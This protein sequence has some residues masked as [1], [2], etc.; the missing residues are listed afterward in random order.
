[1]V[2]I[3]ESW[4]NKLLDLGKR[5]KLIN[6]KPAKRTTL[7]LTAPD[8]DSLF[9]LLVNK[10]K[11]ISFPN[12]ESSL[13]DED[14]K[15]ES[16]YAQT[17]G[18]VEINLSGKEM[19]STLKNL[20]SKSKISN[21]E[22]GINTLFLTFGMIEWYESESSSIPFLS[23]LVLVPVILTI[24]DINSPY[25]LTLHDDEIVVNPTLSYKLEHDFNIKLPEF[26]LHEEPIQR[27][28]DKVKMLLKG[29]RRWS[30]KSEAF[31]S[32]LSF[33]KINMYKDIVKNE[34]K[35]VSNPLTLALINK[36][37]FIS[38]CRE[39]LKDFEM[40]NISPIDL[41]QVVDA[42]SSQQEAIQYSKRGISFVL[43]G[44]P[45]TG[46]SQTITNII[47][48][49]LADGKKVLFVSEKQAALQVVFNRLEQVNLA[50]FCLPLHSFK[51]NRK[52]ILQSLD[53]SL[54]LDRIKIRD[55]AIN[56]LRTLENER[57][58]LNEYYRELHQVIKPLNKSF[59]EI[60][61]IIASFSNIPDKIFSIHEIKNQT[62]EGVFEII[63]TI[64]KYAQII[65]LNLETFVSSPW[66]NSNVANVT[67][68]LRHDIDSKL[69][70]VI[71]LVEQQV[72]YIE[73]CSELL[74]FNEPITINSTDNLLEILSL[75]SCAVDYPKSWIVDFEVGIL[76]QKAKIHKNICIELQTKKTKLLAKYDENIFSIEANEL[77]PIV[78]ECLNKLGKEL[79]P[80]FYP[81]IHDTK[82]NTFEKYLY[83]IKY[84]ATW[85]NSLCNALTLISES[86]GLSRNYKYSD[87]NKIGLLYSSIKELKV[88]VKSWFELDAFSDI[89]QFSQ[90][91]ILKQDELKKYTSDLLPKFDQELFTLDYRVMLGHFRSN[92]NSIFRIFNSNY[93]K[94]IKLLKSFCSDMS[95]KLTYSSALE[96]LQ[97]MKAL[98]DI[99]EWFSDHTELGERYFGTRYNG[100]NT[101]WEE[102]VCQ[103]HNFA[104]IREQTGGIPEQLQKVLLDDTLK[105]ELFD[106]VIKLCLDPNNIHQL[107]FVNCSHLYAEKQFINLD[108]NE[109]NVQISETYKSA[110]QLKE[111]TFFAFNS[112]Q[113]GK[114]TFS[115]LIDTLNL[116]ISIKDTELKIGQEKETL[117]LEFSTFYDNEH[118][119]WDSILNKLLC[120]AKLKEASSFFNFSDDFYINVGENSEYRDKCDSMRLQIRNRNE[121]ISSYVDWFNSLFSEE[122]DFK[123]KEW[124]DLL[125]RMKLC[126]DRKSELEKW[127]DY[128]NVKVQCTELGLESFIDLV[129]K[130]EKNDCKANILH[131]VYLKRFYRLWM[132]EWNESLPALNNFRGNAFDDMTKD[133]C[134]LDKIQLTI[135]QSRIRERLIS[136]IPEVNS[137]TSSQDEVGIL[138]REINKQRKIMPLRKLFMSIP[139]LLPTLKPCLMMSPLSVSIFLEADNY[140]FDMVIFDEASQVKTEDA[141]GAMMRGKQVIITGDNKQL[142]PTNF[143]SA[144]NSAEGDYDDEEEDEDT[145][146]FESVLDESLN[147][148]SE[149]SLKWHYR[150]RHEDLI[151]FSNFKIYDNKLVTFPSNKKRCKDNG[152]EFIYVKNGIYNGGNKGK[153]NNTIE[154]QRVSE[155]VFEHFRKYPKRSLGV[156]TFSEAQQQAV[157]TAIFNARM[158]DRSLERFFD[159][160]KEEAFFI[161]NLENVQGDERDTIIFSIGYAKDQNNIMRMNFG[162][163]SRVGGERRLNVAITRAKYNIKLV[164]SIEPTDIDLART[165]AEGV[166]LLRYY[167]EFAQNGPDNFIK[168]IVPTYLSTDSPFEDSVYDFLVSNGYNVEPQVGCSGYRIDLAVKHPKSLGTYV[169]GIECDGATY[170]SS[171]CAR[172]RDRLRQSVLESI[173]WKIYRI[174]ST[175][176]I[177]DP[178]TE[179][180]KLINAVDMA[181]LEQNNHILPSLDIIDDA[182]ICSDN[183]TEVIEREEDE[184]GFGFETY[185]EFPVSACWFAT[186][187]DI[188]ACIGNIIQVEQPIYF[189]S[190]C[191]RMLPMLDSQKATAR[192]QALVANI[193]IKEFKDKLYYD[194]DNHT[195]SCITYK[196]FEGVVP[197]K[198]EE[199]AIPRTLTE[200]ATSE[201]AEGMIYILRK[202]YG[203]KQ[204]GLYSIVNR[205]FGFK[206]IGPKIRLAL[207][208]A[209]NLLIEQKR[210]RIDSDEK[211]YILEQ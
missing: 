161:K 174:W 179:G 47:A 22:Q 204:D 38:E 32:M 66:Y 104:D 142:P 58:K 86:Y 84:I 19:I 202:S 143:F 88:P 11:T 201:I 146:S 49:A 14:D 121:E 140:D 2:Q 93:H 208:N 131:K 149:L 43:Q 27:Y 87:Y 133:F 125:K 44:P 186:G 194:S 153:R 1:M 45:G 122:E 56:D 210:I 52:Q 176:W 177:K 53:S 172:E 168:E 196:D 117:N 35:L 46:K 99:K 183:Y 118:T 197:R 16:R 154:A 71:P 163:L 119:D 110:I 40:D 5:N 85:I 30:V 78:N 116:L 101:Q 89:L 98:N 73:S 23:P 129:E 37:P 62:P 187:E 164:G 192:I 207:D 80:E 181:I 185:K 3:I 132:D 29:D 158:R 68:Q 170:H 165:T 42:D 200:I 162:P 155:L 10:N 107:V 67:Y 123:N 21:E 100:E 195:D 182:E 135:A 95:F 83:T 151:A 198:S 203:L 191:K 180:N 79:N 65:G 9:D 189:L 13:F 64:K 120:I 156:V 209:Y 109:A 81:I 173:G 15:D 113:V 111:V 150:S 138:K 124:A 77:L 137:F 175:D 106:T 160:E 25:K 36:E 70:E 171:R 6:F 139:N 128:R 112:S 90:Q 136:S 159:E 126:F 152:V 51:A 157:E 72:G 199:G 167:I 60:Y 48:E 205:E 184:T 8:I 147:V 127:I 148:L 188:K 92:Y 166:K 74:G 94:D 50:D 178:K 82:L 12:I 7:Q 20:R 108:I 34:S 41:F 130:D 190:L 18:D 114:E 134:R 57:D 69:S 102:L 54:K 145:S 55:E 96:V 24:E 103:M 76:I 211:I 75:A 17:K 28:F 105:T 33:L 31:M 206:Q 61:G 144:T 59:Y 39:E 141:I 4:K 169:I 63:S 97:N 115:S 91:A 26:D 193:L